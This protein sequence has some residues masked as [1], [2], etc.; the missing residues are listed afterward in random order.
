ML[1]TADFT[2]QA[3]APIATEPDPLR[4]Y[5]VRTYAGAEWQLR[6]ALLKR[7]FEAFMPYFIDDVRQGEWQRGIVKALFPGYIF[8]GLD[9]GQHSD[10]VRQVTGSRGVLKLGDK[11]IEVP[12]RQMRRLREQAAEELM[13]SFGA[14]KKIMRVNVGDW[15]AVPEGIAFAGTPVEIEAI[16]KR[17]QITAY[18][19]S[20]RVPFPL[21]AL[22]EVTTRPS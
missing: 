22:T 2:H 11:P 6:K 21:S 14:R 15:V 5:I 8:A 19:G 1:M 3:A 9:P 10:E 16:D 18:V 7:G 12:A 17:G 4:W 20:I 13:A